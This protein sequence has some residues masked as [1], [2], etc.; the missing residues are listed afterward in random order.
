VNP[1]DGDIRKGEPPYHSSHEP[2]AAVPS[3]TKEGRIEFW[4][5]WFSRIGTA[6]CASLILAIMATALYLFAVGVPA[7]GVG[8]FFM[9]FLP[10]ALIPVLLFCLVWVFLCAAARTGFWRSLAWPVTVI[11]CYAACL[12]LLLACAGP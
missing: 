8:I 7:L 10:M 11:V 2:D 12:G 3:P 6:L 9:F 4:A 1:V 5:R